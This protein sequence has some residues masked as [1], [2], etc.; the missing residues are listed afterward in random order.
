MSH[1]A[2]IVLI[3]KRGNDQCLFFCKTIPVQETEPN[4]YLQ[5]NT[6]KQWA[7]KI[8]HPCGEILAVRAQT[9]AICTAIIAVFVQLD[10]K[11]SVLDAM[12]NELTMRS[13]C[14]NCYFGRV[15]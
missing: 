13:Y 1:F 6:G 4:I 11:R 2:S 12:R 7:G 15:R 9:N 8:L 14:D 5:T 10:C 3:E